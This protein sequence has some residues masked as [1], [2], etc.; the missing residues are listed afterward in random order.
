MENVVGVCPNFFII[1]LCENHWLMLDSIFSYCNSILQC[2][3][4]SKP[5]RENVGN[6]ASYGME[7]SLF[8]ALKDIFESIV[9]HNSRTGVVSPNRFLDIL[10]RENDM[11]SGQQHQDAHEFLNYVLN[12][13]IENVEDYQKKHGYKNGNIVTN[14]TPAKSSGTLT[15]VNAS[16]A[17]STASLT[18]TSPTGWIHE[19]FEGLLTSE[20][21]C[22]TCENVSRRDEQFLDLSI[23]LEK[24]SSVTSCLRNFSASEMLCERNKFHCDSCGGLQEAEKRMKI[25]RLPKV[26]ALH[27]KRF[28]FMENLGRFE[29]LHYRVLYP[30]HLR[31][32]NTTDDAEDPDRLYELY[33]VVVHIGGGPYHGHYVAIV[34]TEDKGWLLFDDELVEP[35]DKAFVRNFFGE[36][37][38]MACAYVLF[39]QETTF[40]AVQREMWV[41]EQAAGVA[42]RAAAEA[43]KTESAKSKGYTNGVN[44]HSVRASSVAEHLPNLHSSSSSPLPKSETP[45]NISDQHPAETAA[46]HPFPP[47]PSSV[48]SKKEKEK[49]DKKD[50]PEGYHMGGI[51]R[52]RSTSRSLRLSQALR[53]GGKDKDRTSTHEENGAIPDLPPFPVTPGPG[54]G[55]PVGDLTPNGVNHEKSDDEKSGDDSPSGTEVPSAVESPKVTVPA[56]A[57]A[58][59]GE[60]PVEPKEEVVVPQETERGDKKENSKKKKGKKEKEKKEKKEKEKEKNKARHMSSFFGLRKKA[61]VAFHSES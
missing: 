28:K 37:P 57:P 29:K 39:Y 4:Y 2:L 52:L 41:D 30:Y 38:G 36:R 17:A 51:N 15:P 48:K 23:D 55:L 33:A 59:L 27:L 40:E 46:K 61:S 21:K 5:F 12:Q 8:S 44:G 26:L 42:T 7:E 11:F 24:N 20:T 31:L 16:S 25:K 47:V 54:P 6:H 22:L 56:V 14:S 19:L 1:V 34:K 35:V 32:F 9:A 45:I 18:S 43:A 60:S 53:L 3:Y 58:K 10:R 13:V 49:G 50:K